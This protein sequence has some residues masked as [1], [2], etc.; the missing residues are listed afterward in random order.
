MKE[1]I[2]T[3]EQKVADAWK[4][5]LVI[6]GVK[7][8]KRVSFNGAFHEIAFAS[9]KAAELA[10]TNKYLSSYEYDYRGKYGFK[11]KHYLIGAA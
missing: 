7:N 1:L 2:R 3:Q 8:I 6:S 9:K 5:V 10:M 11:Y 4:D